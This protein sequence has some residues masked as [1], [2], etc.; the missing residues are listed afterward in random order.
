MKDAF[1][2]Y[3]PVVNVLYFL[4]VLGY[5]MFFMHPAYLIVSFIGAFT[6]TVCLNGKKALR[7]NLVFILPLLVLTALLN[8]LFNHEGATIIAYLWNGNPLTLE[9]IAY[10]AAAALMLAAVVGWFNCFN[11]IITTDKLVYLL[12]RIVPGLALVLSMSLRFVPRFGTQIKTIARAQQ[13]IGRGVSGGLLQRARHGLRILS[14]MITWALENAVETAAGMRGRGYGLPGRTA[15]SIFRFHR[16]DRAAL[17]FLTLCGAYIGIGA[18]YGGLYFRY[19][20][21]LKGVAASPYN[22]SLFAGFVALCLMP[23]ALNITEARQ[24]E[25][26]QS[27]T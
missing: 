15:F 24:W 21:T 4:L 1:A 12:G 26:T 18:W 3:H 13:G 6:Y 10:G 25:A 27:K 9:S 2:S 22:I 7:F 23:I 17:V 16:R 8:P 19:Y 11:T 14:V 5:T 20:P